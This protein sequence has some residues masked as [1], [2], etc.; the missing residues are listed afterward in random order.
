MA[1]AFEREFNAGGERRA[2]QFRYDNDAGLADLAAKAAKSKP[3]AVLIAATVGDF[4]KLREGLARA[5]VKGP[6]LFG[7]EQTAWP[8]LLAESDAG[9][10]VYAVTTFAA[11]GLTPRGQEFAK[12]YRE[13]FKEEPDLYA[14]DAYDGARL[15]F[16][17]MRRAKSER[18]RN[19][20]T[21]AGRLGD[22][23]QPDRPADDRQGGPR[24][25]PSGVRG[26]AAGG[27]DEVGQAL[28][29]E[30]TVSIRVSGH[31]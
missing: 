3:D 2:D 26:P 17:A 19:A 16:E 24:C 15:L 1:A 23:R 28:R 8:A 12:K 20:Y 27:T 21:R 9:R 29:P 18:S 10:E 14:A 5:E 31:F 11:A 30:Q 22:V 7:G 13:H 25:P 4:V 6:V